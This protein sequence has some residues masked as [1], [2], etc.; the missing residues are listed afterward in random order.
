[1]FVTFT[2]TASSLKHTLLWP[3]FLMLNVNKCFT[4]QLNDVRISTQACVAEGQFQCQQFR[5]AVSGIAGIWKHMSGLSS[6][7]NL[8]SQK[9]LQTACHPGTNTTSL[10]V[11][12]CQSTCAACDL[13][14]RGEVNTRLAV[15]WLVVWAVQEP[16]GFRFKLGALQPCR[17]NSYHL[18]SGSDWKQPHRSTRTHSH[19][20]A[21]PQS[22]H[23]IG[24]HGDTCPHLLVIPSH[25]GI[26]D[27]GNDH[28]LGGH[29]GGHHYPL[30]HKTKRCPHTPVLHSQH[31]VGDSAV[32]PCTAK[33]SEARPQHMTWAVW[34]A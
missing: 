5:L 34:T 10:D 12:F 31:Q 18:T 27:G 4:S 26:G 6:W 29:P 30:P 3:W 9:N 28:L 13:V 15:W 16:L 2:G 1:M 33:A 20:C 25:L 17:Y 32:S 24:Q 8:R 11:L 14:L 22:R 23:I 7:H 21:R 19:T